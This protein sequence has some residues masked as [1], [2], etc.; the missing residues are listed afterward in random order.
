MEQKN[1]MRKVVEVKGEKGTV[2]FTKE[3]FS[4]EDENRFKQKMKA[5][6]LYD[7]LFLSKKYMNKDE[8]FDFIEFTDPSIYYNDS[9]VNE[10][11]FDYI[12]DVIIFSKQEIELFIEIN[13][14]FRKN[15]TPNWWDRIV[16]DDKEWSFL[17]TQSRIFLT[18]LGVEYEGVDLDDFIEQYDI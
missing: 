9:F 12:G 3:I 14:K 7:L 10:N 8:A 6:L 4:K 16:S 5:K 15:I 2:L 13:K 17:R 18:N 1:N 11:V